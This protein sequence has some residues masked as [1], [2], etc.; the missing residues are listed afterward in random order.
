MQPNLCKT[1]KMAT[2]DIVIYGAG[3]FGRE[4]AS[5]LKRQNAIEPTWNLIGFIDDDLEKHPVGSRNEYGVILGDCSYLNAYKK[6]LN[7]ILAL[8]KPALLKRVYEKISNP[9]IVFP[10]IIGPDAQIL[11]KDNFSMGKGNIICSFT[12]MSCYVQLGD[13]NIFNNRCSVGHDARIGNFNTCMTDTRISGDTR[14]GDLNFLGVGSIV[15]QGVH[16]GNNTTIGAGSVILHKT[17][18]NALYIGNPAK[19]VEL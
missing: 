2:N 3:G 13:F 10:N 9:L 5:L 6:P 8:G 18:D 7:V 19:K 11:D 15:I 14:I 1:S 16:I 4:M 12:T 17:K